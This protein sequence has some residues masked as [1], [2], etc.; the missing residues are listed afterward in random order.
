MSLQALR[1]ELARMQTILTPYMHAQLTQMH[2]LRRPH[3]ILAGLSQATAWFVSLAVICS[4]R[5][6]SGHAPFPFHLRLSWHAQPVVAAAVAL[7]ALWYGSM[8][9]EVIPLLICIAVELLFVAALDW[10]LI[11]RQKDRPG[12]EEQ[13]LPQDGESTIVHAFTLR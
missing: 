9:P 8:G 2:V 6:S 10:E 12:T 3:I 1:P 7:P 5:V 13:L 4:R 11:S